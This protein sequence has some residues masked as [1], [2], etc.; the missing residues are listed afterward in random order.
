MNNILQNEIPVFFA[1]DDNYI[2][3]LA[4]AIH[5]LEK[6][7]NAENNYRLIILNSEM[8]EGG[9]A[10]IKEFEK[11]NIKIDFKD[12]SSIE[13]NFKDELKLRLRDYY[14]SAIYYRLFIPSLFPE[15]HKAI[16]IDSDIVLLDDIANLYNIDL[17]G[18]MIGAVPDGVV[19]DSKELQRYVE[20]NDGVDGDKY[21]NSG[22]L[23][24]DLDKFREEKVEERF[25]NVLT[26]YNCDTVAPDQD[27]LNI[28]C[29]GKVK[30]LPISWDKMPDYCEHL[31]ESEIHL[32]H[33]N[34]F[35]KPWHYD[36]VEYQDIFWKFA[37][38]TKY[39]D[40][41]QKELKSYTDEQ[42]VA[43]QKGAENMVIM[44]NKIMNSNQKFVDIKEKI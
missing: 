44:A 27:Y 34:M 24:I 2:P 12:I 20:V 26:K 25:I 37:K 35:R 21:F 18:N 40:A 16:Y 7:A 15:Y 11:E 41:L 4:V 33:Y 9:K 10:E 43:D 32:I 42:K 5:S 28:L 38:E 29:K 39:Y 22:V 23:L 14:S 17:E 13:D 1:S 8:S 3:C 31:D 30:Y 36:D 19:H 6:H